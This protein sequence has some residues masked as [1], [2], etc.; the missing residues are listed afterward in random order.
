MN[1]Y[2]IASKFTIF[3]E[4]QLLIYER[5][6]RNSSATGGN[7]L[8]PEVLKVEIPQ[9]SLV[10]RTYG[11]NSCVVRQW[12]LLVKVR[13]DWSIL[14]NVLYA[15]AFACIYSD[16]AVLAPPIRRRHPGLISWSNKRSCSAAHENAWS[17]RFRLY[18]DVMLVCS[19]IL[20]HFSCFTWLRY[21][22]LPQCKIEVDISRQQFVPMP[23]L[24]NLTLKD[25]FL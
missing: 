3:H 20:L 5:Q 16:L 23:G 14:L 17:H 15:A 12:K 18:S 8:N 24:Q 7:T 6:R 1:D 21:K 22:W 19:I 10:W 2:T 11:T 4:V 9:Q 25:E 13:T